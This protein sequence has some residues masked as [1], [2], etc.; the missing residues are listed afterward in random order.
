MP[1]SPLSPS[2]DSLPSCEDPGTCGPPLEVDA[3]GLPGLPG[4]SP[5]GELLGDLLEAVLGELGD[6]R[7]ELGIDGD[8]EDEGEE[9][10]ALGIDGEDD[11]EEEDELGGDGI[12]EGDDGEELG[13]EGI[14]EELLELCCVD[15]QPARIRASADALNK[16]RTEL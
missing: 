13:I 11:D 10:D 8:E 14:D 6:E 12:D 3:V 15:S 7:L 16:A 1:S 9:E 2:A 5:D 4:A